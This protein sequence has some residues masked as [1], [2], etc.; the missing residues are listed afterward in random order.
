MRHYHSLLSGAMLRKGR[1]G[2]AMRVAVTH[3][4]ASSERA[5]RTRRKGEA[6]G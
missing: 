2:A 5:R 6:A 1:L 4:R 3:V